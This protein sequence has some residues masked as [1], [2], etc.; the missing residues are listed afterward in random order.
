MADDYYVASASG[1]ELESGD[2]SDY[3]NKM[4]RSTRVLSKFNE[5]QRRTAFE[6]IRSSTMVIAGANLV[7]KGL[8]SILGKLQRVINKFTYAPMMEGLNEY[9]AQ[10]TN[11]QAIVQNS[12]QFYDSPGSVEHI[13]SVTAALDEL[14]EYA[15]KTIYKFGDMVNAVQGFVTA[16]LTVE[17]SATMTKGLAS[18]TAFMGKGANQYASVAYMF[19]QAMQR[20][21]MQWYQWRSIEAFSAVGGYWAKKLMIETAKSMGR[22]APE[23]D[24]LANI[25]NML[26]GEE[27]DNSFA[28]SLQDDWL[29]ADVL[30]ESMKLLNQEYSEAELRAKGFSEEIIEMAKNAYGQANKV[31]TY[32]QFMDAVIESIGT[33]WGRIF[34]SLFGNVTQATEMWTGLMNKITDDIG[35]MTDALQDQA[36]IFENLGGRNNIQK[37]IE[38]I[39]TIIKKIGKSG[40]KLF[41]KIIPRGLGQTLYDISESIVKITDVLAGNEKPANRF[42]KILV[43]IGDALSFI[44]GLATRLAAVTKKLWDAT[45]P[46]WNGIETL[47]TRFGPQIGKLLNNVVTVVETVADKLVSSGLFKSLGLLFSGVSGSID[48]GLSGGGIFGFLM[49]LLNTIAAMFQGINVDGILGA[50][51]KVV[52]S[53]IGMFDGTAESLGNAADFVKFVIIL[54]L[55]LSMIKPVFRKIAKIAKEF[56]DVDHVFLKIVGSVIAVVFALQLLSQIKTDKLWSLVTKSMLLAITVGYLSKAISKAA[57]AATD[58][59]RLIPVL[60]LIAGIASAAIFGLSKAQQAGVNL[61]QMTEAL[62]VITSLLKAIALV[63][64]SIGVLLL[65]IS[66]KQYINAR[67]GKKALALAQEQSNML[68]KI[69]D[70]ETWKIK[71]KHSIDVNFIS[72]T[73]QFLI[74]FSAGIFSIGYAVSK[75]SESIK[76]LGEMNPDQLR[77]GAKHIYIILGILAGFVAIF[78][79]LGKIQGKNVSSFSSGMRLNKS[80]GESIKQSSIQK[81]QGIWSYVAAI[82]AISIAVSI[83]AGT[84][85]T[86]GTSDPEAIAVGAAVL[87]AIARA[88]ASILVAMKLLSL[89]GGIDAKMIFSVIAV[90]AL[91]SVAIFA[92]TGLMTAIGLISLFSDIGKIVDVMLSLAAFI[93]VLSLAMYGLSLIQ[94]PALA[95]A[96]ASVGLIVALVLSLAVLMVAISKLDKNFDAKSLLALGAVVIVLK[97]LLALVVALAVVFGGTGGIGAGVAYAAVGIIV[98][99]AASMIMMATAVKIFAQAILTGMQAF[100]QLIDALIKIEEMDMSHFVSQMDLLTTALLKSIPALSKFIGTMSKFQGN[101]LFSAGDMT[102]TTTSVSTGAL[103]SADE[104]VLQGGAPSGTGGKIESVLRSIGTG[105]GKMVMGIFTGMAEEAVTTHMHIKDMMS[106][107]YVMNPEIPDVDTSSIFEDLDIGTSYQNKYSDLVNDLSGTQLGSST[108]NDISDKMAEL[109]AIYRNGG[110]NQDPEVFAGAIRDALEGMLVSLDGVPV[111]KFVNKALGYEYESE[112]Y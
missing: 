81:Q 24:E 88:I 98:S 66:V 89:D 56:N 6:S 14:N 59:W 106:G 13:E 99:L 48:E 57:A 78:A 95:S 109:E 85:R 46:L 91:L 104:A 67:Y 16:G 11:F 93:G 40:G 70:K 61:E 103:V 112:S 49:E 27:A 55:A 87:I 108:A 111:G 73:V 22:D 86:L 2:L 107:D 72:R 83:L 64:A 62:K 20:G 45:D 54:R 97:I 47:V 4:K 105:L 17:D 65:A 18:L 76:S 52:N 101:L 38:N 37:I 34:R 100:D 43:G 8:S 7:Y 51:V 5:E 26:G 39:W 53:F 15:D 75:I 36:E 58:A 50:L 9:T 102:V 23:W 25:Y 33:G 63:L 94:G 74:G 110:F 35:E 12:A 32:S 42:E 79:I 44:F 90:A 80:G 92:I 3:S 21:K 96:A 28:E 84:L 77:Q 29:T 19:N 69:I 82:M 31:R 30:L 60:L 71:T 1:S 41:G 68:Q 10:L